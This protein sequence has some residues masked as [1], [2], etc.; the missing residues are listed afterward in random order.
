MQKQLAKAAEVLDKTLASEVCFGNH[1]DCARVVVVVQQETRTVMVCEQ[2][3][4]E[5]NSTDDSTSST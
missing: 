5:T 1:K 3:F 4:L 2:L